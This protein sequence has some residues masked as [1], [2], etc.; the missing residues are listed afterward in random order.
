M[1][2]PMS[3]SHHCFLFLVT[4]NH[5]NRVW[6]LFVVIGNCFPSSYPII[7]SINHHEFVP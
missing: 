2:I 5:E 3:D 1:I 4:N 7:P 6:F